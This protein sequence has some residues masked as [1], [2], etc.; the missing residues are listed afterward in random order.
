PLFRSTGY[1]LH[2]HVATYRIEAGVAGLP[3]APGLDVAAYGPDF[4]VGAEA[5]YV[6]VAADDADSQVAAYVC[7]VDIGADTGDVDGAA[8][9]HAYV[10]IAANAAVVATRRPDL[11]P[12]FP[13]IVF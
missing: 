10:E 5:A 13:V 9:R 11:Y 8:L 2:V 12:Y 1:V 6:N 7:D 4:D 3:P